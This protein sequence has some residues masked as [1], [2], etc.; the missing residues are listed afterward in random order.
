MPPQLAEEVD[1]FESQLALRRQGKLDESVF[2]ETRLRRGVY[3][4]RYDN[5][6]R[7]DGIAERTLAYR[8]HPSKGPSTVW[9]APGMVRIK[10]PAG[11]LDARQLDLLADV[12]EEYAD[13]IAHATTRQDIQLHFVHIDDTPDLMRRLAAVGITTREA[14]G[15]SVRNVTACPVA[16]VCDGETFDV[17]P[18]A[19]ACAQF[20]LGHPDTMEFGRKFKISF[21]GCKERACALANMHDLG[22]IAR[23]RDTGSGT[24]RGFEVYVGG[25]LGAVPH[26]AKLLDPFVT[27]EEMLPLAQAIARVFARLGEKRNRARAR[28][29]FVV[30]K[31]G[32]DEFRRLVSEERQSLP[33]DPRWTDYLVELGERHLERP[34]RAARPLSAETPLSAAFLAWRATN[35]QPQKQGEYCVATVTLPLGDATGDQLRALAD[36]TREFCGDDP[37]VRITVEQNLALR[38]VSEADLPALH[39]GLERANLA[40]PGG[41][42]LVDVTACPGTDT[43]KLGISAS[44][45]LARVLRER[46]AA[47]NVVRDEAVKDLR[48]KVSGCFNSCGQHHVS[49]LGFYGVSRK[50]GNH[51]VPHFQVVVGGQW[52]ENGGAYG[53]AIGAVP[54]KR[55]PDVVS[56]FLDRYAERREGN[57]AF[58][59]FVQRVG[60]S[61]IKG[62]LKEFTAVPPYTE[63]PSFY[64]DWGDVREFTT[65]DL[66]VGECAGAVVSA[67][68]FGLAE[69]ERMAFE[70]QLKLD[71]K[72]PDEAVRMAYEAMLQAAKTL[73]RLEQPDAPEDAERVVEAFRQRFYDTRR[74]FDPYAGGKFAQYLFAAHQAQN[75]GGGEDLARQ[76]VEEAQLFIEAAHAFHARAAA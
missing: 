27:P 37:V 24:E 9:D 13:G 7:H 61:E 63:D 33:H 28:I 53:L 1:V 4:Q 60:K 75:V 72:R 66:G 45:G 43:C 2:A 50:L 44:R 48:I 20:L 68:D 69:S 34:R 41:G 67:A 19:H 59:E 25:G 18:Y 15:N 70:A 46:L 6:K 3:G 51:T 17:T 35:V 76:R 74:F 65:G 14:C 26:Q 5:G 30:A 40:Q 62:W 71:Q 21:S 47:R 22:F 38:W 12:A 58:R 54:S 39:A 23:T 11:A 57:E 42:T 56:L 64:A 49:D 16:G 31:L 32:I 55:V 10:I 8:E 29:K 36:L 73:L 52:S